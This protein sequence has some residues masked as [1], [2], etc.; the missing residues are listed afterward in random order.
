MKFDYRGKAVL[1]T[2]AARGVGLVLARAFA[3][4]G[5]AVMLT[6][7]NVDKVRA[8]AKRL[9]DGGHSIAAFRHDVSSEPDWEKAI[10]RC[11][12]TFGGLDVLVNNAGIEQSGL[13]ADFDVEVFRRMQDVNVT[14]TFLGLK[15][16][17]RAMRPGGS[18][19]NGGA[20][21]NLSSAAAL[22]GHACLGPYAA[23]KAAVERLTKVA[24]VEAGRLGW[25]VRVNCL[26]PG[27][28]NSDVGEKLAADL[29]ELGFLESP[30]AAARH[31]TQRTPLGR[32]GEAEDLIGAALLLCSD[33]A[34]YVTGTGIAVDGGAS[35]G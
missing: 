31:F 7:R 33:H 3:E 2:G 12:K 23:S 17:L 20:I 19:G 25:E 14:G 8:A 27:F 28:I 6:D 24:A 21:L 16:G 35:L 22:S 32:L 26:Y 11:V 30:A 15:H 5:A 9:K 18:A 4:A 1:V 10:V 29:V 34:R 13:L